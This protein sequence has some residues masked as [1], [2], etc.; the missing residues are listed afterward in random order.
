MK[1]GNGQSKPRN[2]VY[3]RNDHS[4]VFKNA[5]NGEIHDAGNNNAQNGAFLAL[6]LVDISAVKVVENRAEN[7][8]A[9]PYRLSPRI[10]KQREDY[11]NDILEL[12]F[13]RCEVAQQKQ[14]QEYE[15]KKYIRK[16]QSITFLL[17]YSNLS[18]LIIHL[19]ILIFNRI[20]TKITADI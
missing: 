1:F 3:S 9:Y 17:K 15:Q 11:K 10:E 4:A 2:A 5:Q 12:S 16:Y 18:I 6:M 7:Q 20:M 8:Q 19:K 14:R 13:R